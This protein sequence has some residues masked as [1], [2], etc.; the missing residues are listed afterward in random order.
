MDQSNSDSVGHLEPPSEGEHQA[1]GYTSQN[2][3]NNPHSFLPM[4]DLLE[5]APE[6]R[7]ERLGRQRPE[8]FHSL[9][10]EIGFV[11][12]ISMSQVLTVS[13]VNYSHF[14]IYLTDS[15]NGKGIFCFWLHSYIANPG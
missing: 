10:A 8:V 6:V 2:S 7:I 11:F 3:N 5:E 15:D 14:L 13:S 12:S 4:G 1:S 9:W